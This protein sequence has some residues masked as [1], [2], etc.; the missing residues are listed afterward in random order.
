VVLQVWTIIFTV[1]QD[2]DVKIVKINKLKFRQIYILWHTSITYSDVK[3]QK[4]IKN[5][6]ILLS[7][8]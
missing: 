6:K 4:I 2:F 5:Y 1:H 7:A 3:S 8:I